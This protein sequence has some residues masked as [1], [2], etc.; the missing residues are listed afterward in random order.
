M[1]KII[2]AMLLYISSKNNIVLC[3]NQTASNI[4]IVEFYDK[5]S[6]PKRN[7]DLMSVR[8]KLYSKDKK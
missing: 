3:I 2:Y 4:I 6:N 7:N 5:L 8:H 1:Y